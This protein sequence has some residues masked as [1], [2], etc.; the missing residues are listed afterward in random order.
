MKMEKSVEKSFIELGSELLRWSADR[1]LRAVSM[2]AGLVIGTYCLLLTHRP[3]ELDF[4][5][6]KS[7]VATYGGLIGAFAVLHNQTQDPGLKASLEKATACIGASFALLVLG[8][9]FS[10]GLGIT[11]ESLAIMKMFIAGFCAACATYAFLFFLKGFFLAVPALSKMAG[12]T[13]D[14]F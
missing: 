7:L 14:R 4:E 13:P 12:G 5:T 3:F 11:Q 2:S 9:I 8:L 10:L 1:G 6:I